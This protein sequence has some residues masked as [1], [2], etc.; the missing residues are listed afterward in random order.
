MNMKYS[1]SCVSILSE[2]QALS[3][4]P[5]LM[6]CKKHVCEYTQSVRTRVFIY[7]V[8]LCFATYSLYEEI[9]F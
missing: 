8:C 7:L 6:F 4:R 1:P 9:S 5:K 3:V 2:I